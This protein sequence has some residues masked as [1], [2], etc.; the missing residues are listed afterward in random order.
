MAAPSLTYSLT[1]GS[2]ADASQVMQDLNDIINGISDG[3][4]DLTINALT[5]NGTANLKGQVNLGD[6]TADDIQFNGSLATTIGIKTTNLYNIGSATKGLAGAYFGTGSTQT[7]QIVATG[8]LAASRVYTLLDA[9]AAANF[10]L[11]E[12]TATINGV[13]TF[14]GQLIGKGTVTND[15]A[16]AGYFGEYKEIRTVA[17]NNAGTSSQFFDA[18]SILLSAGDWD[19]WAVITF[20]RNGATVTGSLGTGISGTTGNSGTG[21]TIPTTQNDCNGNYTAAFTNFNMETPVVRVQS[22]GTNLYLD[23]TTITSVQTVYHK[24]YITY[25]GT[26]QFRSFMRA[27]RVR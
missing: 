10:V 21:L 9:G 26:A 20:V 12:G 5:A 2:T 7:A 4:K 15:S 25:T 18:N 27:R 22:D 11:S 8:T 17:S 13:K 6:A 24:A 14:A 23:G 16:A 3:T 19:V 1:N